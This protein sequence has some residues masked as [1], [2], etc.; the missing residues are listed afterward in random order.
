MLSV[1][2]SYQAGK[3]FTHFTGIPQLHAHDL[4]PEL[5]YWYSDSTSSPQLL[6]PLFPPN[7]AISIYPGF[8]PSHSPSTY[9]FCIIFVKGT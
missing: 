6:K 1:L 2:A 8:C 3:S 4:N 7:K 9:A 5:A